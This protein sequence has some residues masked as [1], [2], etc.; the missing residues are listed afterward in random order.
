[1]K[2]GGINEH[3]ANKLPGAI[4]YINYMFALLP[5][6]MLTDIHEFHREFHLYR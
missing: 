4:T 3:Y 6:G 5:L 2:N 1:M